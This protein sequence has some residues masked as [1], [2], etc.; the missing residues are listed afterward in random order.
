MMVSN[1]PV[2]YVF[3]IIST[4]RKACIAVI[5]DQSDLPGKQK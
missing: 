2:R 1:I 4:Q 3:N 5:D